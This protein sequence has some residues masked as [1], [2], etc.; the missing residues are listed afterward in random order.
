MSNGPIEAG[1]FAARHVINFIYNAD[2]AFVSNKD[3]GRIL[4]MLTWDAISETLRHR[5]KTV[6][7]PDHSVEVTI[8]KREAVNSHEK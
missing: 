2:A 5:L 1:L 4:Q 7:A 8:A 6:D 3:K